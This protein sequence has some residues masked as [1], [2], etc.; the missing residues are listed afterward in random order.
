[1][2]TERTAWLRD[3]QRSLCGTDLPRIM[4]IGFD[5]AAG[6]ALVYADKTSDSL[7]VDDP[8]EDMR[9]GLILE[10]YVAE[11]FVETANRAA[12]S[13][14][15]EFP[16]VPFPIRVYEP[17]QRLMRHPDIPW[18]GA[19][20]DRLI[21]GTDEPLECKTSKE[22]PGE[23]WGDSGTDCVPTAYLVQTVWQMMVLRVRIGYVACV[24][25]GW[26][27]C[28]RWY[29]LRMDGDLAKMLLDIA[30]SFWD[31]VT[32]RSGIDGWNHSLVPQAIERAVKVVP[33]KYTMLPPVALEVATSLERAAEQKR[34]AESEYDRCKSAALKLLG[35]SERGMMSDGRMLVR[36]R[37]RACVRVV[38]RRM[39]R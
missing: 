16:G 11:R 1:M 14:L 33:H 21:M 29:Q 12:E 31:R 13:G 32:N 39:G 9:M 23:E 10:P 37:E 25:R 22:S 20:V 35:D 5:G 36:E 6:P 24:F 2:T 15:H 19:T 3:R 7:P 26:Q 38:N 27:T 18:M 8:N 28:F 34:L 17:Q 30:R 4:G